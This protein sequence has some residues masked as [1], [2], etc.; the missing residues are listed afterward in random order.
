M[1]SRKY[2][3]H[4]V[5]FIYLECMDLFLRNCT[6]NVEI[7]NSQINMKIIKEKKEYIITVRALLTT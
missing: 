4:H 7:Q 5:L 2:F 3:P 1:V 6:S